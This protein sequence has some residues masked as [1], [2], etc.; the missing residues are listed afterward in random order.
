MQSIENYQYDKKGFLG[1]GSFGSVY[2]AKNIKTGEIVA[3][4]ILD[5][6]LFQDQFMIDS[7]K[8]EIK[9]MQTLT[10]PNVVRMLDV[11]GNKQQ[12]YM[13]IEL[14]DSDL[15]SVMHKKGHI[16][17]QQAIELLAQLMNGFKDLV[18][19]N[20]IH[21]DIKPEN[22]L[23]KSN[24]YKVADFGFAT[25]IDITGRQ[26]LR[27]C[28]GTPIYMSPQILNKQQY[29][30]KSDIWSIG[31]M[32]YEILF[33]KTAWSCRDMYSLLKSIKTQPL[34]FPYERPISENSKDFIKKCLM[35]EETNR[36]GWNEIFT[37][38]LFTMKQSGQ[39]QQKQ[40]YELPQQCIKILRKMQ[41]VVTEN[42]IDPHFIFQRFDKDKNNILDA[43]E[44]KTL[45]LAVDP[46]TTPYQI[47]ALFSRICGQDQKVNYIEFQKLFTEFDF[48]D[49]ND[50]AG[51]IIKDIQA[52]I[53]ANNINVTQ[54][55]NKYDKNH[56]G[57]LDYQEFYNLIKVIVPG[58]KDYEIQL[59]F[60]KF[61]R[62][63]NGAIS[64]PEFS[65]ILSKGTG[66]TQKDGITQRA[67]GVLK[68]L[69][70]TVRINKLDVAKIF[71][72]FDKSGDG[73]ID[74][75]EFFLLLRAI[76]GKISK[77]EAASLFHIFDK[78]HDDQISFEEFKSQL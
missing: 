48:S 16:Q 11:F 43:Q 34:R 3:L 71:Q 9:V 70:N 46:N 14:C 22:C 66:Q 5:M 23:V 78:N 19:H 65:Y 64:F 69:Q 74:Q 30:A 17:E 56:Q 42:N 31:M 72:R 50:R 60:S 36:I 47:Q 67:S 53:K 77:N 44:F 73:A 32:Y 75:A 4:K 54:I 28:V 18:S 35:I 25:K 26:L 2:K 8:N 59:M 24:V 29:S 27:E 49:L 45:I 76:D 58:I 61:D 63:N 62:D 15:R 41:D 68:Q 6:K 55:F 33:G 13:A 10:S 21:R 40:N 51:I 52:V 7:L 39:Q 1:A 12:T 37:H 57:D 38:P 20:Y